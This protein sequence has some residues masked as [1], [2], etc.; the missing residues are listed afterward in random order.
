MFYQEVDQAPLRRRV[1]RLLFVLL[2]FILIVVGAQRLFGRTDRAARTLTLTRMREVR[3]ALDRYAI[4]NGGQIPSTAQ[5]LRALLTQPS[6]P[7]APPNWCGP[8]LPKSE[9]IFDGWGRKFH[10][11][12]PGG[13]TPTRPYDLW[14]LGQ[15]NAEGGAGT[16]AD[17]RSWEPDT[18][19]P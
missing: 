12:A 16:Q 4:D 19:T 1:R 8:Y 7:A 17:L 14:S 3:Q 15:D 11:T 9:F 18:L 6:S 5:G 10:Y 13:G 2:A